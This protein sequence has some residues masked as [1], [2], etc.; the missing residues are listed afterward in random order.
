MYELPKEVLL[1]A[2]QKGM[3]FGASRVETNLIILLTH[4]QPEFQLSHILHSHLSSFL[5]KANFHRDVIINAL[6]IYLQK[7]L[8]CTLTLSP[9]ERNKS[10]YQIFLMKLKS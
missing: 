4:T 10:K 5:Q 9:F 1:P 7:Y 3:L 2:M 6:Q 8:P